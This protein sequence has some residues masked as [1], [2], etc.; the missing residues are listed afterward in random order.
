MGSE[1]P[2]ESLEFPGRTSESRGSGTQR[3]GLRVGLESGASG[4]G[5]GS[6]SGPGVWGLGDRERVSE[7][8]GVQ[9]LRD[10]ERGSQ[11][12]PRVRGL[13]AR[14]SYQELQPAQQP[15]QPGLQ[16]AQLGL[17]GPQGRAS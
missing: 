15:V 5:G 11:S 2:G 16:G 10:T 7:C 6:Q 12:G 14:S 1:S 9:G 3:E 8:P 13:R 17:Q 4:T